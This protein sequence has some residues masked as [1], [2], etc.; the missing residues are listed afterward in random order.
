MPTTTNPAPTD[1]S[2]P[3]RWGLSLEA[4]HG[5]ADRLYGYW[6]RFADCFQTKTRDGAAYAYIYLSGLLRMEANRNFANIGRKTDTPGQNIQH[7]MSN[8][9]WSAQEVIRQV[10]R[11]I[12]AKPGLERGGVLILDESA[13]EKA[14]EQSAGV[15]RQYNGR[16]GK[17]ELSQVGV[18]L[19]YSNISSTV[20]APTWTWVDGELYLPESWFA[21]SEP[22][23]QPRQHLG[24]PK[25]REFATK[26]EL[27]WQMIER[28]VKNGLRC[29]LVACD[30]NYGRSRWLR[31]QLDQTGLIYMADVPTDT[32]VYLTKPTIGVP[33]LEPGSKGR[34]PRRQRVLSD[35]QPVKVSEVAS[36]EDTV[37]TTVRVRDSERGEI[38]DEFAVRRVWARR[39]GGRE[40]PDR[41]EWLVIRRE[42]NGRLNCSLSNATPDST[43]EQLAW[44]K[45]QRYFIERANQDAKSE[46]GWD[47]FQAQKYRAWEHE[48][49]LSVLASWFIAETKLDWA[50]QFG[51][52]PTLA[53]QFEVE[54]LPRLS[55]A[56]VREML[57]ATMPLPQLTPEEA[58]DLVVK[59]LVNRTRARR[60][61][62]KRR[63][64]ASSPPSPGM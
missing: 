30:D 56:N 28:A 39:A 20:A 41:E 54:V 48:L 18:F 35:E 49:A 53:R 44:G 14:G 10:Q 4:V 6:Q 42:A 22:M 62:T 38:A 37:W 51:R 55:T 19:A 12:I 17:V 57:R 46:L 40:V 52:D 36:R 34:P 31:D 47:E 61:R 33:V 23:A 13:D 63:H 45:C 11:E 43:P 15:A 5:L 9:P 3:T 59:H 29:E 50:R 21:Q 64:N 25:E 27:G 58:T 16:L 26:V 24:I 32:Q 60:S 1:L 8:S 2:D 7:F